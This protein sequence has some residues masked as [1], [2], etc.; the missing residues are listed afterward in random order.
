MFKTCWSAVLTA[1]ALVLPWHPVADA[2]GDGDGLGPIW[3]TP[4]SSDPATVCVSWI[5]AEP[6][7]S[8]VEFGDGQALNRSAE[9]DGLRTLHHVEITLPHIDTEWRYRV[10]SGATTSDVRS[11]RF[12]GGEDVLRMAVVANLGDGR[13]AWGDAIVAE[14]PHLLLTAGDNVADLHP[15]G[16]A[17][18]P[19][20]YSAFIRLVEAQPELFRRTLFLPAL[21]NHDKALRPRG[22]EPPAEPVYDLEATAFRKFFRLP[23]EGWIWYFDV[24]SFDLQLAALDMHHLSDMGTTWQS[25]Q[26]VEPDSPQFEW[27]T[28]VADASDH[29][30]FITLYNERHATV[31]HLAEGRWWQAIS[32]GSLAVT[33]FGHYGERIDVDGF[34]AFDISVR[35][36]GTPYPDPRSAVLHRI[37]NYLLISLERGGHLV[38]ELRDF[39]RR[40]LPETRIRIPPRAEP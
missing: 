34:P 4:V 9:T 14:R 39:E 8:R 26:P 29:A 27:F 18:D 28:R 6:A 21:G 7:P 31:R 3:L 10:S 37:D 22:Q 36:T 23:G 40:P 24:P 32:R 19:G 25:S 16:Q 33:G 2:L 20:D 12:P 5:T 1:L 35:G 17:V 15:P 30:F 13:G 38:A 11:F